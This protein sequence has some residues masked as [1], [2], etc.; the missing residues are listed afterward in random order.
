MFVR[1]R[2]T[3]NPPVVSKAMPLLE[4]F[5]LMREGNYED[6]PVV[7]GDQIVGLITLWN[8]SGALCFDTVAAG[9]RVVAD[10]ILPVVVT[11]Y[12]DDVIEEAAFKMQKFKLSTLP[13]VNREDTLVGLI[14]DSDLFGVFVDMLGL[15]APGTRVTLEAEDK[16][17]VLAG[18]AEIVRSTGVNIASV[19]TFDAG[20][21]QRTIVLRLKTIE[22]K[23]VV[24]SLWQAGYRV[25][26]VT[27]V[28]E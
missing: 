5:R 17:G 18:I 9:K 15:K 16:V 23:G 20:P 10:A 12:E 26:H 7:E 21:G 24:D 11:V 4:V 1:D 19:A 27:Q 8:I 25:T 3:P 6:L 22:A 28:W 14:D 13:V 2:M